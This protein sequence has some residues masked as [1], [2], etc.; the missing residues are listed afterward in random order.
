[1][2]RRAWLFLVGVFAF[3]GG[4]LFVGLAVYPYQYDPVQS[5]GVV[6]LLLGGA[7]VEILLDNSF[8]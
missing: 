4:L 5:A 1:M 2:D 3:L 6:V 8:D 7:F